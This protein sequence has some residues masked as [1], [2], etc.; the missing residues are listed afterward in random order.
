[1]VTNGY[2]YLQGKILERRRNLLN[3]FNKISLDKKDASSRELLAR[4]ILL[5]GNLSED[6]KS[7]K[8]DVESFAN[9]NDPDAGFYIDF[10]YNM[11]WA[12]AILGNWDSFD[13]YTKIIQEQIVEKDLS[14]SWVNEYVFAT[15]LDAAFFKKD[16]E[17]VISEFRKFSDSQG[18]QLFRNWVRN[19]KCEAEFHLEK[20]DLALNT[21]KKMISPDQ[22]SRT[23]TFNRP[24]GYYWQGRIYEEKGKTQEAISAYESL[25]E[26]WKDGDERLPK[27]KD[28][29]KRLAKLKKAS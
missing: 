23:F 15:H 25:M 3:D 29:I 26:L 12:H 9:M 6:Q 20:Y 8:L 22:N 16:W 7:L 24:F 18:R 2:Y 17:K 1:M 11:A 28:A 27:R 5:G 4:G 21:T 10:S 13:T 14:S 19:K